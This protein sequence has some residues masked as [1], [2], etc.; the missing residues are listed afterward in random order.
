VDETVLRA[1]NEKVLLAV[2]CGSLVDFHIFWHKLYVGNVTPMGALNI[3]QNKLLQLDR[4]LLSLVFFLIRHFG[5]SW[6]ASSCNSMF[7]RSQVPSNHLTVDRTTD[8]YSWVLRMELNRGHFDW[9]L[10]NVIERNDVGVF[11]VENQNVS[12]ERYSEQVDTVLIR[13]KVFDERDRDK[14]LLGWVEPDAGDCLRLTV[15]LFEVGTGNHI[16]V[17]VLT[18]SSCVF[19]TEHLEVIL[20]HINDLVGLEGLFYTVLNAVN[21]FIKLFVQIPSVQRLLA[22]LLNEVLGFV[23]DTCVD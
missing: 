23:L 20:E 5:G 15:L 11:K 21:K 2:N 16:H 9:R 13:F 4:S 18:T 17:G 14:V 8:H 1:R 12:I 10:K 22:E 6:L 7:Q 3:R 19:I